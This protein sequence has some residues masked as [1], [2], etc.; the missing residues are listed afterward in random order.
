MAWSWN[1][2]FGENHFLNISD[3]H[4]KYFGINAMDTTW[5][6]T[7]F[8]SKTNYN[9][10]R[11]TLYWSQNIIK[12][13]VV[14]EYKMLNDGRIVSVF[15]TEHDTQLVTENREYLLPLT[16]RGKKKKV[17]ATNVLA[18]Y[19]MGCVFQYT[20]MY[21]EEGP[22]AY[23]FVRN[24]RSNQELAIG[25][26]DRIHKITSNDEFQSFMEYYIKTCPEDYFERI[27]RMR[28]SKHVTV[29]YKPG[30]IFR[31]ELDR[32]RYG[33][34]I[35]TGEIS[36]IR[37]WE[38][39]PKRHSLRSLMT[40]PIMVRN[41]DLVTT[42]GNLSVEDLLNVPL[43]RLSICSDCDIIWGTHPIIGHK[44]LDKEDLEFNIVCTKH[45][46]T[47][48]HFTL[49][50]EES[51]RNDGLFPKFEEYT[52]YVE[53]G[54]ASVELPYS[55]LSPNLI[56]LLSNYTSPHAGVSISIRA[57][58]WLLSKEERKTKY[59]WKNNLLEEYN[60]HIKEELFV[61][62]GLDKNASFDDFARKYGGLSK[63]QILKKIITYKK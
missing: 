18:V 20:L 39:L 44:K 61:C 2:L 41:Y 34:G 26:G 48:D 10:K 1:E 62:L 37:K 52:L 12:K 33:Y 5:D 47:N 11:V 56:Q 32:F 50:T 3:L 42:N 35:I 29:K 58:N 45:T 63:E 13:V 17:N 36:K 15:L 7:H 38:E 55:S 46:I 16:S 23:I 54:T 19:P 22:Q 25:E 53:W 57:D 21:Y 27:E 14:D 8:L 4:R 31:I 51:F 6:T 40:V 28:N 30:D 43:D 49:F 59:Y 24:I 60:K 9:Y